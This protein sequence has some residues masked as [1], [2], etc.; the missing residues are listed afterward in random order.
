MWNWRPKDI[1]EIIGWLGYGDHWR[2]NK[3]KAHECIAKEWGVM[4]SAL[5]QE[6]DRRCAHFSRQ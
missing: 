2:E 3:D 6:F 4:H 1:R 5:L